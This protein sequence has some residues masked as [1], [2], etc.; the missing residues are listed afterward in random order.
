MDHEGNKN[1]SAWARP[2]MP[3][4]LEVGVFTVPEAARL[5]AVSPQQVRAWVTGPN[6]VLDNQVGRMHGQW[7]L[8]FANLLELRFVATFRR[9]GVRQAEIRAIMAEMR[10]ILRRPHPF[11]TDLVFKTDGKR[12]LAEFGQTQGLPQ[13]FDLKS[14][15]YEMFVVV[16]DSLRRDVVFDPDG[17]AVAWHPRP[18]IAPNVVVDPRQ[19]FGDPTL[20]GHG[21]TTR[22]IADA[23]RAEGDLAVVSALYDVAG[24][25]VQEA[26]VFEAALDAAA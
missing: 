19:S 4:L 22:A 7:A 17:D 9:A 3:D 25:Q 6:P 11:A 23:M 13:L 26:L 10:E 1:A 14:R 18:D 2:G 8:G 24:L 15:N 21:I 12:I 16:Y 20:D 5:I